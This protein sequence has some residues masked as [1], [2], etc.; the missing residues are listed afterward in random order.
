MSNKHEREKRE[1]RKEERLREEGQASATDRRAKLLQLA[2]GAVFLVVAVV[3][4]LIVINAS[5]DD[6]GDTNLEQVEVV[7]GELGGIP[8]QGL[9]LGDP[10]A[11]VELVEFG[12]LQC[13]VCKS[14]AEDVLPQVIEGPVEQ[15]RAK[16]VFRNFAFL[17]EQSTSAG[18]AAVAAGEQGRGWHYLDVFYR[19]QGRENSGYADDEFL[20]AVAEAAEVPDLER[21]NQDRKRLQEEVEETSAE[22]KRLGVT[23]TPTFAVKGPGTGGQLEIVG[24]P[25]SAGELEAAIDAAS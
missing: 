1:K 13:P 17:G 5:S 3:V 22:A 23:G 20:T 14:Y 19:N 8:Q 4:V 10:D 2:A 24:T 7:E 6:G 12:D 16:L 21:W 11:P 9:V 15:G 25:S 18:A